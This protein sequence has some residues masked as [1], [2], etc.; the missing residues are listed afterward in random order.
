MTAFSNA[1]I[2]DIGKD[3]NAALKII[4]EKHGISIRAGSFTYSLK[5]FTTKLTA[6]IETVEV[7]KV[8]AAN[9][10]GKKF[11]SGGNNVYTILSVELDN[12]QLQTQRGT[13]Y[14]GSIASL[15]NVVWVA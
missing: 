8:N 11:K 4:A 1:S 13:K 2:N 3:L 5:Q 7:A 10:V 6:S 12:V 9:L 14:R 15:S